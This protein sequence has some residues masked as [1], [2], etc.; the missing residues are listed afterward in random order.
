MPHFV[1]VVCDQVEQIEGLIAGVHPN[2]GLI[3]IKKELK[4]V[5][6]WFCILELVSRTG[7]CLV[8]SMH[9]LS[10]IS[11]PTVDSSGLP[12]EAGLTAHD[13]A[14]RQPAKIAKPQKQKGDKS[15]G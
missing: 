7:H 10:S 3:M 14:P 15:D 6:L 4:E 8:T 11:A 1:A 9:T 13:V 12:S 5:K 2:V